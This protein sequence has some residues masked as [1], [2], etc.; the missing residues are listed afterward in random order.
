MSSAAIRTMDHPESAPGKVQRPKWH[1][2]Y[3]ALASF[4]I[5]TVCLSLLL[6]HQIMT[7]YT[8]SV[9]VNSEWAERL[10][11]Y[12]QLGSLASKVNA[13]GNRVFENRDVAK[14]SAYLDTALR[15]F[16]QRAENAHQEIEN[17]IEP[18]LRPN[19]QRDLK[20][21]DGRGG[22]GNF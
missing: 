22:K 19:L 21:G 3:Y 20:D 10:G 5:F 14:E 9:R 2:V 8:D 17:R 18:S 6:S 12:M 7:I 13:P 1:R 16:G 11:G 15:E 4:D